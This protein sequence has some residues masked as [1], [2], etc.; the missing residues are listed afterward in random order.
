MEQYQTG[1]GDEIILLTVDISTLGLAASKAILVDLNSP[2]TGVSVAS[3]HDASGDI[4]SVAIGKAADI[5]QR[6]LS[7]IT[8]IDLPGADAAARQREFETLKAR[9][10]MS[11]AALGAAEFKNPEKKADAGFNTAYLYMHIDLLP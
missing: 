1:T 6:R 9:Y 10:T 8:K 4:S 5:C 2:A 11:K 3:S 7:V